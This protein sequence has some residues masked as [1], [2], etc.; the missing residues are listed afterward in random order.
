M[1]TITYRMNKTTKSYYLTWN[2]IQ[3]LGINRN[4]KEQQKKN[5]YMCII[6]SS[7]CM[8][9]INTNNIANQ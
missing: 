8:A 4:G 6:E 7:C 9:E 5:A 3:Y 2:Y 1:Q